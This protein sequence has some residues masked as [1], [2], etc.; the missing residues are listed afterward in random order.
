MNNKRRVI[1][2][3]KGDFVIL[4]SKGLKTERPYKKLD[5]VRYDLYKVIKVLGTSY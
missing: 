1:D 5:N 4:D 2:I 3:Y